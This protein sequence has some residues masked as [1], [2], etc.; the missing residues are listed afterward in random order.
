MTKKL[1]FVCVLI[2]AFYACS[3]KDKT[4]MPAPEIADVVIQGSSEE[5]PLHIELGESITFYLNL[6]EAMNVTYSWLIDEK[7][8]STAEKFVFTP[9]ETGEYKLSVIVTNIDD[10][11][12]PKEVGVI[13]VAHPI[14]V[15]AK[16]LCDGKD[17]S[18]D[19]HVTA[20]SE[21]TFKVESEKSEGVTYYWIINGDTIQDA[22][23]ATLEYNL[24][25][26]G[27]LSV[28]LVNPD[29]VS[30][31]KDAELVGPY[32][33]GTYFFGTSYT[34]LSFISEEGIEE[35]DNIYETI[36]PGEKLGDSGI[37]DFLIFNNK[38][39]ILSPSISYSDKRAQIVIA[40]AQTMKKIAAITATGFTSTDL[41]TIYNLAI[42]NEDKAYIGSNSIFTGNT[43]S[44]KVLDLK[45]K[46]M[47]ESTIEGTSGKLGT[48]GPAWARMLT[49]DTHTL[50]ACGPKIQVISH[51]TD[52]VEKTIELAAGQ[53]VDIV[54]GRDNNIYALVNGKTTSDQAFIAT[55][56][57]KTW[58]VESKEYMIY[59]DKSISFKGGGMA[60][61]RT[62]VS[63]VSDELIFS[64]AGASAWSPSSEIYTYNYT[65]KKVDLFADVKDDSRATAINGYMGID[66]KGILFV[67]LSGAYTYQNE[68]IIAYDVKTRKPQEAKLSRLKQGEGNAF[69]TCMSR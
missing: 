40:D 24:G 16:L 18:E 23:G 29:H 27:T 25:L 48:E 3:D 35:K 28:A 61:A 39:Y 17:I 10:V 11:S 43:S 58:T 46:K 42:A 62:A 22:N 41:G 32:K 60:N 8:A 65:S 21:L 57:P 68:A 1:L 51:A 12:T 2:G 15:I 9:N 54:K 64:V 5:N 34:G 44:V 14:P 31:M 63:T 52:K 53:V 50:V 67:P 33:N 38:A 19:I 7:E 66:S 37:N 45:E 49:N 69:P 59:K 30:V 6:K 56:N 13:K 36:N 55:I 4:P 20:T 26:S 47:A